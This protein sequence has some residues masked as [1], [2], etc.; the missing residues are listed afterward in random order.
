VLITFSNDSITEEIHDIADVWLRLREID[1][2]LFVQP[3][4]PWASFFGIENGKGSEMVSV[5]PMV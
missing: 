3:E 4:K 1:G 2:A 5:Q